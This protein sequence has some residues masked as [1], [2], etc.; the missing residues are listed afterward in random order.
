VPPSGAQEDRDDI[1]T[2]V[3]GTVT[4]TLAA[5][6]WLGPWLAI[7]AL[8][9]WTSSPAA[10]S[11]LVA[12]LG[13]TAS[14]LWGPRGRGPAW[15]VGSVLLVGAIAIGFAAHRDVDRVLRDF[16]AYWAERDTAVGGILSLELDRRLQASL[17]ADS[18]LVVAWTASDGGLDVSV[19]RDLR[20]RHGASALA[21]YGPAGELLLWDGV[22]RG[23]VPESVQSGALEHSYHDLPLFGYLY[24]TAIAEDGGVAVAAH[25]LRS[26]L[27]ESLGA[28]MGDFATAFYR[29]TGE[30]IRI[31]EEDPAPWDGVV[32]DLVQEEDRI[33]SVVVDRPGRE[34]RA[35]QIMDRWSAGL[36]A[37]LLVAWL[38]VALG[39][40]RRRAAATMAA[41]TL[42]LLA[43][44]V[45]LDHIETFAAAFDPGMFQL[46]GPVPMSLGRFI[47][48][49][50]AAFTLVSVLPR[51]RFSLHAWSAGLTAALAFPLL[52]AWASAGARPGALAASGMVFVAYQVG[53]AALLS[54]VAGG[55]V[56]LSRPP[57][58]SVWAALGSV[59]LALVLGVS[60]AEWVRR[61]AEHPLW[62]AALWGLPVAL[63]TLGAAAWHGWRRSLVAWGLGIALGSSV[64][65]PVTWSHR[66]AARM[67]V[68]EERLL[69]LAAPD[70]PGLER[71]L[72]RFA[73]LADSLDQAGG[74]DVSLIYHG[75][76]LSGL[77]DLGHPVWLQIWRRDGSPGEALRVGVEGE[78]APLGALLREAWATGGSRLTQLDRDDARYIL[79]V[80]LSDEEVAS[81][82]APPFVESTTRTGLG[83]LLQAA[84]GG[85][86]DLL[87]VIP[88]F[89]GEPHETPDLVWLR[90]GE[91]W[92][93]EMA[94]EFANGT[95][96][97]AHYLVTLP[98]AVL[99]AA[100]ATLLLVLNLVLFVALWLLGQALVRDMGRR[101]LKLS[102]FTISF[103]AR[104]TL[105]LF[106]FFTIA[107]AI[108]G[109]VAYRTL[110]QASRRSA[111]VIAERVG[112]DAVGWYRTLG[113]Q[114]ER[115]ARQVGAELLEYREGELREG[116]VPELVEL[117]LYEGW[118]PYPVHE[119]LNGREE[120]SQLT[121][122]TVGSWEYVTAYRRLPD[123]DIL[124]AQVPL[125]AGTTALQTTDLFELLGFVVLL[126]AL[127]S[128]GLAML[129]GRALTRPIQALLIASESVG[130]GD[131]GQRLPSDR[132]D[133]FGAVFRA[134]NRMVGRV[135]RAR[136]QLVRTSMRT[137]LIMD[138]AAVGMVAL[139]GGGRITL[140]NP[141]AEALL[142]G[143][144]VVG[145]RLPEGGPLSDA[146]APWLTDFLENTHEEADVEFQ[147]GDRR[148]RVRVRRLGSFATSRGVVL[149]LDDV[150]DELRAERV[151]AWGQMAR[152]VAHEVKNPLTPIKLSIQHVRRAWEDRHPDFEAILIRNADAMLSEI[153]RLAA[154]AQSFSRFGAPGENVAPLAEVSVAEVIGEV[155][156]LYGGSVA[157]VRFE[158]HIEPGLPSVVARSAELKE[159]LV[160][161]L[162][163]ARLAGGEGTGVAIEARRG[164]GDTVVVAV[165]DNGA[166]IPA[167]V[168][169]RIFEPQFSTRSTGTGLG[170]AIV[171]RL[172]GS[173]GGT[174]SVESVHGEGTSV[175]V[176][177][178]S[179]AR[180]RRE[181]AGSWAPLE[182]S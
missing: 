24:T 69:A 30:R 148:V 125:Q 45:P 71:A 6:G 158:Q 75:W 121:E 15:A 102:G 1:G 60:G 38:L 170:L 143:E 49:G 43:A 142:G 22:H 18:Q 78:P 66:M 81:V 174:V 150:T 76:R 153:E 52:L 28:E 145:K 160:N 14:V 94:L 5:A 85:T 84:G 173:W 25:L 177:L 63:A 80:S 109:T 86:G 16:D 37:L 62:W 47:L 169:P 131:L 40:P 51:P 116:S 118:V 92:Q 100:R 35:R 13:V 124:G 171:Q 83:P 113:G 176:A 64:A 181:D 27:P 36:A 149:A 127:L 11:L 157:R 137:Q 32:W 152:Q 103:R 161:L 165:V 79:T 132:G 159:V 93:A 56:A 134:F 104:V 155:M 126:G 44:W 110:N 54:I 72:V 77:A 67:H 73:A 133:E 105:A 163:N 156:A 68:G 91:G 112:E 162:E 164:E 34:E 8:G 9:L 119:V 129:A 179:W 31:A 130:A 178:R 33:L 2:D 41:A 29:Q 120:V 3:T 122:T 175:S 17:A 138:E 7:A 42:L 70:D 57:R 114:M 50:I 106:G 74:D 20:V 172:V 139:D 101:T 46:P 90:T 151:L 98:G 4:R 146:L 96:Y 147:A 140:A 21:L 23:R 128:A 65:I 168:L 182:A 88:L 99:A 82:V 10:I 107:N 55:L 136:R 108:F 123:G 87:T 180:R 135:R 61:T 166:G 39:G 141:R 12:A 58:R 48:V 59:A 117:G 26:A 115:L 167:D 53:V 89:M 154:I 95:S 97:H 111:Q 19:V 144:V